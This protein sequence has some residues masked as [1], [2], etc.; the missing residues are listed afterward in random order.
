MRT[1][2]GQHR[3]QPRLR[4]EADVQCGSDREG[5]V[6]PMLAMIMRMV[7]MMMVVRHAGAIMPW[8]RVGCRVC[9]LG[10]PADASAVALRSRRK[11]VVRCPSHWRPG[12]LPGA[13][14]K[15]GR[16]HRCWVRRWSGWIWRSHSTGRRASAVYDAFCPL[17]CA[18]LPRPGADQGSTDRIHRAVR[19][20]GTAH[21][22]QSRQRQ[23]AGAHRLQPRT[24]TGK[25]SGKVGSQEWHTDKSFRPE[26]SLATILHAVDDAAERRR[27]LLRQHVRGLRGAERDREGRGSTGFG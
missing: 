21:R 14:S 16:C 25:P 11:R 26:P 9:C 20:A 18:V 17:P 3:H 13:I 23:S 15:F 5:T 7:V 2:H 12:P 1:D 24:P 4:D 6:M 10:L 22:A 19:H 8:R 27:H